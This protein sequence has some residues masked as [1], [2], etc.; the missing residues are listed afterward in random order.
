MKR[1]LIIRPAT[2]TDVPVLF[3]I[4][5]SVGENHQSRE[6]LAG[7]GVTEDAVRAMI[8]GGE[9]VSFVAEIDGVEAGFTMAEVAERYVFACFVKPDC[10]GNGIGRALMEKTE[11]AL[12]QLGVSEAWL[13]TGPGE[14]L[15]AVG[16]YAHLGWRR[17]G[18]LEDGQIRFEKRLTDT[19]SSSEGT[20]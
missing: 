3:E 7:I 4:R 19:E 2:E 11:D 18:Y 10:E 13:S 16:F 20:D 14:E 8:V 9:Y 15:R 17:N 12:R 5:C 6:E 1:N